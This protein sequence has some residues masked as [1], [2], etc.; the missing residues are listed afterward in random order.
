MPVVQ[1]ILIILRVP[2]GS[3]FLILFTV[4]SAPA[5][6]PNILLIMD[7]DVGIDG[8][9]CYGGTSYPTPHID[10]LAKE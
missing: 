5:K 2:I 3:L 6:R 4:L 7:D 10:A 9:G 1:K 8:F